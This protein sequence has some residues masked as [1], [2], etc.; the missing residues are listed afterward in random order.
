VL[1]RDSVGVVGGVEDHHQAA[2]EA[3]PD[4]IDGLLAAGIGEVDDDGVDG[5]DAHLRPGLEVPEFGDPAAAVEQRAQGETQRGVASQQ[6][7]MAGHL[8]MPTS[9]RLRRCA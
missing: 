3:R 9:R 4:Q 1:G 2:L 6:H 5:V 8:G 7:D